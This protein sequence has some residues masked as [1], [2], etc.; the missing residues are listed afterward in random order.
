MNI[1]FGWAM[2]DE[3]VGL[4]YFYM[5]GYPTE[6]KLTYQDLPN[7]GKGRWLLDDHFNG[8]ILP[9]DQLTELNRETQLEVIADYSKK[10]VH[11]FLNP[12]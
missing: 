1:G 6:K 4:P 12:F 7:L 3:L 9:I 10:A 11:Y 5:A 2:Q 8:A